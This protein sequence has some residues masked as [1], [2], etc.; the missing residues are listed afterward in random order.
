MEN[1]DKEYIKLLI[2]R[3]YNNLNELK[4]LNNQLKNQDIIKN[5]IQ[6]GIRYIEDSLNKIKVR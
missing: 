2:R 6:R 4:S 3:M 1:K 5:D